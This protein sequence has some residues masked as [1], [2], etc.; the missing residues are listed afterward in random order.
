[1]F[2]TRSTYQSPVSA[3]FASSGEQI[4]DAAELALQQIWFVVNLGVIEDVEDEFTRVSTILVSDFKSIEPLLQSGQA[5]NT[6]LISVQI[7]TP[8]HV[9]GSR[10][11]QMERLRAVWQGHEMFE[12][13]SIP[14]EIF[15]TMSG[16]KYPGRFC[17][18]S[19]EELA[20]SN[21]MYQLPN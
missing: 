13:Q 6:K 9:N 12:D 3:M 17:S 7:V 14:T 20:C 1:M 5:S 10:N 4:W 16:K 21:L 2:I 11:W 15:E 19:V 8:D 18:I